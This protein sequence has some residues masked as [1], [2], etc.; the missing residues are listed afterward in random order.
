MF[1][2]LLDVTFENDMTTS[3]WSC[4]AGTSHGWGSKYYESG[5]IPL[6]L[7]IILYFIFLEAGWFIWI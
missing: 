3:P 5:C 2:Y 7:I 1:V 6:K 4:C